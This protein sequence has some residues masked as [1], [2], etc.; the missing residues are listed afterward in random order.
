MFLERRHLGVGK[1]PPNVVPSGSR[2]DI[3]VG[4]GYKS[5]PGMCKRG[6]R[7]HL[8]FRYGT[9]HNS[10]GGHSEID[11]KYSD[12]NGVTWSNPGSAITLVGPASGTDDL[13]DPCILASSSGRLVVGFDTRNPYSSSVNIAPMATYSDDG[14]STWSSNYAL[15]FSPAGTAYS[16]SQPIQ[17]GTDIWMPGTVLVSSVETAVYWK[18]TDDGATFPTQVTVA[19][20][21]IDYQEP[22]IRQLDSGLFV[23]L[24]R[25]ESNHHTWRTTSSDGTTWSTPTDVNSMTGRPD[26]VA[27]SGDSL[28]QFGRYNTP[29]DSPGYFAYSSNAGLTWSTPLEIDPGGTASWEYGAPVLDG[30]TVR[31]AY[32]LENSPSEADLYL[33]DY[34]IG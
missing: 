20:G 15:P 2:V 12:D 16:T 6:S 22:Q 27:F 18:S 34:A 7:L 29:A 19:S 31:V 25:S 4:S 13:R 8:V 30:S 3:S 33:R 32:S 1:F 14:G 24:L 28:V 17:V 5:F 26:F 21:A 10:G 9:A 23:A 11:Y